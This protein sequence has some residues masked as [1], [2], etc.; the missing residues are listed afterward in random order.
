MGTGG[1]RDLNE[2]SGRGASKHIESMRILD[3]YEVRRR[4]EQ[5]KIANFR[6]LANRAAHVALTNR[7]LAT[8]ILSLDSNVQRYADI[9]SFLDNC[10]LSR[11]ESAASFVVP[12]STEEDD[13]VYE[14]EEWN[15]DP[16]TIC[17]GRTAQGKPCTKRARYSLL[18]TPYCGTHYPHPP[19]YHEAEEARRRRWDKEFEDRRCLLDH[20]GELERDIRSLEA[21][22]ELLEAA[23]AKL[24]L[25]G[26]RPAVLEATG[27]TSDF[28]V[29]GLMFTLEE[30]HFG[31]RPAWW[32][33]SRNGCREALI[34]RWS[35]TEWRGIPLDP[36]TAGFRDVDYVGIRENA[37]RFAYLYQT[38]YRLRRERDLSWY[39]RSVREMIEGGIEITSPEPLRRLCGVENPGSGWRVYRFKH[40]DRWVQAHAGPSEAAARWEYERLEEDAP[41]AIMLI[42]PA[43][44]I[45]EQDG[46]SKRIW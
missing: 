22:N 27:P 2:S 21:M 4:E 35:E 43:H 12:E 15:G 23:M 39:G 3:D 13:N 19:E 7:A 44:Q 24:G 45:V 10:A 34:Q 29:D 16:D 38:F 42:D 30:A 36:H 41:A 6:H 31:E 25:T 26:N 37:L 46:G 33:R 28:R 1:G 8:A 5:A 18:E 20:Y 14:P 11:I 17:S 40:R 9:C 32:L